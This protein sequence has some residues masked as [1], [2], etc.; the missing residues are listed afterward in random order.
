M[1]G[2]EKTVHSCFKD[3]VNHVFLELILL[4]NFIKVESVFFKHMN[5]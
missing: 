1:P 3:R 5:S 4:I 2:F